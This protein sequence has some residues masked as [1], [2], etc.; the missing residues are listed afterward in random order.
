LAGRALTGPQPT[1]AA[2]P[3]GTGSGTGAGARDGVEFELAD[4]WADVL[5][6]DRV[7][8][9]ED[10][11]DLGGDSFVGVRLM[12][13]IRRHFGV[14][15][16]MSALFRTPTVAGLARA[17][18][19][20]GTA[21][22][23]GPL[24]RLQAGDDRAPLYLFPPLAGTV[25]RYAPLARALDRQRTVYAL[26]SPGLQPGEEACSSITEMAEAYLTQMRKVH[27]GGPWH[28][29]GYSMGGVIA[30]EV[31]R[32]LHEAG[33]QVGL[34]A[35]L[36]TNP[37]MDLDP[38]EDYATR[39]LVTMGL[40]LDLDLAWLATLDRSERARTL[41]DRGIAAGALPADYDEDRLLRMLDAYRHNGDALAAHTIRRFEGS[42]V[43]FRAVDRS[44]D[45]RTEA[46]DIG[47]RAHCEHLEIQ[48]VPGSHFSM[49]DPG[50]LEVLCARIDE[51]LRAAAR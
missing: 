1:G 12:S 22:T 28:L 31:A 14:E 20:G 5:G 2:T 18:R 16:P 21:D 10:F 36:D 34:V 30:F 25:V 49:L 8:I 13:A 7:G 27:S 44:A 15:L 19:E 9:E 4:L 51:H 32:L 17:V 38:E 35:L 47:W 43:L 6:C 46:P 11:F 41:L 33:E 50:N 39:I 23:S 45:T 26:Q 37:R 42:A 48:E 24:V 29:G 40:K 3:S